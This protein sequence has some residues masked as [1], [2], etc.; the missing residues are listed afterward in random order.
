MSP[1]TSFPTLQ[2]PTEQSITDAK[3]AAKTFRNVASATFKQSYASDLDAINNQVDDVLSKFRTFV[4]EIATGALGWGYVDWT[5]TDLPKPNNVTVTSP[6]IS[7]AIDAAKSAVENLRSK[8]KSQP[9]QGQGQAQNGTFVASDPKFPEIETL[10]KRLSDMLK[11]R[12]LFDVFA[13]GIHQ[14][15]AAA[16]L[17]PEVGAAVLSSGYRW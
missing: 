13:P 16:Q 2:H 5:T 15:R 1:W 7:A 11:E 9:A 3:V 8:Y 14:L 17:P 12:Y 4:N 6:A 10:F